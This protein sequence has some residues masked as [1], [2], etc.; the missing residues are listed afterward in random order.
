[1]PKGHSKNTLW[2]HQGDEAKLRDVK[3]YLREQSRYPES[4]ATDL[5]VSVATATKY[6][7]ILVRQGRAIAEPELHRTHTGSTPRK[8]RLV[9]AGEER[10]DMD[11]VEAALV[12]R[13]TTTVYEMRGTG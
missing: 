9:K 11:E 1:M 2:P 6:L 8:Y 13:T 12:P 4:I 5:G 10:P 7:R 3:R